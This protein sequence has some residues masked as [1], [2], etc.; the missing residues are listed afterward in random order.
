MVTTEVLMPAAAFSLSLL[1]TALATDEF[2]A[3]QRPRSAVMHTR[4]A[5][6]GLTSPRPALS[7][8]RLVTSPTVLAGTRSFSA[9]RSL[10]AATIFMDEVIFFMFFTAVMR[11]FMS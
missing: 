8:R 11:R 5:F 1:I 4:T 3:P 2:A 6:C 10:A 9:R 7:A